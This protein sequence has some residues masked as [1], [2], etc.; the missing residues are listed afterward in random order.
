L[1]ADMVQVRKI[2]SQNNLKIVFFYSIEAL[3]LM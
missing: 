2:G 1:L 3:P